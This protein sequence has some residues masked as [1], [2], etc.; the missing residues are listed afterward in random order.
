MK[1]YGGVELWHHPFFT[2]ALDRC[3]WLILFPADLFRRKDPRQTRSR[4]KTNT[5]S[6]PEVLRKRIFTHPG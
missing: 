6:G 4:R 2:S 5:K 3:D 1:K